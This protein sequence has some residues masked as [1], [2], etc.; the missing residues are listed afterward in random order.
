[1]KCLTFCQTGYSSIFLSFSDASFSLTSMVSPTFRTNCPHFV[2]GGE[3]SV[4]L[5]EA[6]RAFFCHLATVMPPDFWIRNRSLTL[7][8]SPYLPFL[9]FSW[10][11]DTFDNAMACYSTTCSSWRVLRQ[12]WKRV[13]A[14]SSGI[15]KVYIRMSGNSGRTSLWKYI[16]RRH[17]TLA[18]G[19]EITSVASSHSLVGSRRL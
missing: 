15:K 11:Y 19:L 5:D 17:H 8:A 2:E 18:I 4:M 1:M 14:V 16:A 10:F 6:S 3:K 12:C 7:I 9:R 13:L